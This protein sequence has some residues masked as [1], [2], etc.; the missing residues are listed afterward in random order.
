MA[1]S[2]GPLNDKHLDILN[3]LIQACAET[4]RYCQDCEEAGLDVDPERRKN[5][6]QAEIA[7]KIKAKFFPTAK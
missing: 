2:K 7:R 4:E 5:A 6:E 3:K 1:K